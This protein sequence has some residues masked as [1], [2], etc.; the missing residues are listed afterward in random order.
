MSTLEDDLRA[1]LRADAEALRVPDRPALDIDLIEPGGPPGARWLLVA[2]CAALVAG[3]VL[4]V[5][6]VR[7]GDPESSTLVVSG[8]SV[9]TA[10]VPT[11]PPDTTAQLE[12]VAARAVN[13]W[14]AFDSS[15]SGEGDIYLVRPGEDAR[16]LEV[17]GSETAV[18]TCPAWSPD[19]TRLLFGRVT[20]STDTPAGNAELVVVSVAPDGATGAPTVIS[21]DGYVVN[22]WGSYPCG[23]WASDGRWVALRGPS[24]VWVMDTVSAAVRRLPDLRPTDLEWRP[25]TDQLAIAGAVDTT[26]GNEGLTTPVSIYSTSTGELHQL[27]SVEAGSIAWS[28]DGSTLA[29]TGVY[30]P[31]AGRSL[32][33][34]WLVNADG[35]NQRLLVA[36]NGNANHGIGPVWSPAGDRIAYQRLCCARA[37]THEVVLVNVDDGTETVIEPPQADGPGEN[38][39]WYP[40]SV[41]WS[42]DGTTLLYTAWRSGL[43][44][45][46]E[47]GRAHVITVPADAPHN[48]TVLSLLFGV[49]NG[50]QAQMWGRQP[51]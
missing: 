44:P 16:R 14:V 2:T 27:G 7:G 21:L 50:N 25:G 12:D 28:P 48:V 36:D 23:I 34:L 46:E 3:G 39:R 8:P 9:T 5:A 4:V 45:G 49:T 31:Q 13:G 24:D 41:S 38:V 26:R 29:Y 18:E 32:D 51:E 47:D 6:Q 22:G 11:V 19:G 20:G 15:R 43:P 17:P 33:G 1:A 10:P 42:P 37:E 40:F 30:E 35:S